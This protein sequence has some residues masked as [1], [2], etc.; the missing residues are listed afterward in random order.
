MKDFYAAGN[1]RQANEIQRQQ[2][3]ANERIASEAKRVLEENARARDIQTKAYNAPQAYKTIEIPNEMPAVAPQ[4]MVPTQ[5]TPQLMPQA[6]ATGLGGMTTPQQ[7]PVGMQPTE[8][9]GGMQPVGMAQPTAPTGTQ[10]T[11]EAVPSTPIAKATA[12]AK[13]YQTAESELQKVQR[14]ADELRKNGLPDQ[15]DAYITKQTGLIKNVEA[16]KE[17]HLK[18]TALL[19]EHVAGL[20]NSFLEAVKNGGDP[21]QAWAEMLIKASAQGY[22]IEE[23]LT[24]VDPKERIVK[25]NQIVDEA[26]STRERTRMAIAVNNAQAKVNI[27]QAHD[28]VLEKIDAAKQKQQAWSRDFREKKQSF[29]EG[30]FAF[31]SL[32]SNVNDQIKTYEN[33]KNSLDKDIAEYSRNYL[34]FQKGNLFISSSGKSMSPSE[35]PGLREQEGLILK[36]AL[37]GARSEKQEYDAYITELSDKRSDLI[38]NVPVAKRKELEAGTYT[39]TPSSTSSA[40]T[41]EKTNTNAQAVPGAMPV[42]DAVAYIKGN[43]TPENRQHFKETYPGQDLDALL[44][45]KQPKAQETS[46]KP[47]AVSGRQAE[48]KKLQAVKPQRT[49]FPAT[50]EGAGKFT[51]A[52]TNWNAK[53]QALANPS[54]GQRASETYKDLFVTETPAVVKDKAGN[55]ISEEPGLESS[56]P[57]LLFIGGGKG[58]Q[59]LVSKFGKPFVNSLGK[60]GPRFAEKSGTPEY[61]KVLEKVQARYGTPEGFNALRGANYESNITVKE[62]N[63]FTA[64]SLEKDAAAGDAWAKGIIQDVEKFIGNHQATNAEIRQLILRKEAQK[65]K[66]AAFANGES[67][68][69]AEYQTIENLAYRELKSLRAAQNR[70]SKFT[71]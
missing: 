29:E 53:Y 68:A 70:A 24:V 14:V 63:K 27:A 9:L 58:A 37:D 32:Y 57:E 23:L 69:A 60:L 40:A 55:I 1:A 44:S 22:P 62:L 59:I 8:N 36:A 38:K 26:E 5:T 33:K 12:S 19:A 28:K 52:I 16:A 51:N 71:E 6:G 2:I 20:G 13:V 67:A 35:N 45:G 11:T 30:K 66:D 31:K 34:E 43:D 17:T 21:N 42:A 50:P 54:I 49:D 3:D 65:L 39:E 7:A 48:I 64:R 25:A 15:A 61:V 4:G 18:N 47:E 10:P 56:N 46:A 41:P